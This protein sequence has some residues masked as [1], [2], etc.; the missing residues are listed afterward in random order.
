[1]QLLAPGGWRRWLTLRGGM[2]RWRKT[3]QPEQVTET[4]RRIATMPTHELTPYVEQGLYRIGKD[5][6]D[7]SHD[8]EPAFVLDALKE[9]ELVVEILR[10]F[11]RRVEEP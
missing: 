8:G 4:A 5:L 1:M 10:E 7:Y 3:T 6:N 11:R 2:G 9:A